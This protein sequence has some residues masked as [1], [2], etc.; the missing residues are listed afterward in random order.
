MLN[1]KVIFNKYLEDVGYRKCIKIYFDEDGQIV[2]EK[3][4]LLQFKSISMNWINKNYPYLSFKKKSRLFKRI[5]KSII[6][7]C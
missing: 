7:Q 3:E 4:L 5:L 2:N 6:K 1:H